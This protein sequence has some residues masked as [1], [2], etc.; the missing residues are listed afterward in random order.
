[1]NPRP[2]IQC[3]VKVSFRGQIYDIYIDNN[4]ICT[5]VLNFVLNFILCFFFK[6]KLVKRIPL[7][8]PRTGPLLRSPLKTRHS[9][10]FQAN[11]RNKNWTLNLTLK[12]W[13]NLPV[14]PTSIFK[15]HTLL[16]ETI[17]VLF[18]FKGIK[19]YHQSST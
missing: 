9:F 4:D 7:N 19:Y 1:M 8:Y 10:K 6:R 13:K 16:C 17:N 12:K 18:T 15:L 2:H 5:L 14:K 11:A 3:Y